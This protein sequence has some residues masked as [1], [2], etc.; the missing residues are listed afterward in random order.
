M[1]RIRTEFKLGAIRLFNEQLRRLIRSRRD[2]HV[3]SVR[4]PFKD[5]ACYFRYPESTAIVSD[6]AL[7]SATA[8]GIRLGH[9]M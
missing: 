2:R 7:F 9:A 3:I 6:I 1:T 5:V 8:L 4:M